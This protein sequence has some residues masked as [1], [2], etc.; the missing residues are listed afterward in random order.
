MQNLQ[1]GT[2][3]VNLP[4]WTR[5]VAQAVVCR[6]SGVVCTAQTLVKG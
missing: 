6:G 2:Q 3:G 5:Q 4:W 1:W